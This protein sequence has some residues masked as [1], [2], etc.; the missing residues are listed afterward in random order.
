M[1]FTQGCHLKAWCVEIKGWA[2]CWPAGNPALT[3]A[4]AVT[5][6]TAGPYTLSGK[7]SGFVARSAH[8]GRGWA[9]CCWAVGCESKPAGVPTCQS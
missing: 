7:F 5:L 2:G 4:A 9:V 3:T 8:N 6:A 1:I